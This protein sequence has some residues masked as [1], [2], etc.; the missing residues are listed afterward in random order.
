MQLNCSNYEVVY[1][2]LIIPSPFSFAEDEN[3][4]DKSLSILFTVAASLEQQ[5]ISDW[6]WVYLGEDS[7]YNLPASQQIT[8]L[9]NSFW[10]NLYA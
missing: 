6:W 4:V 2:Y 8:W 9:L 5:P 1:G 7:Y 10:M 3:C